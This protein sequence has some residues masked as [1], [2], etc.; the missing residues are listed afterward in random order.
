[1]NQFDVPV[2][3]CTFN[4]LECTKKVFERIR[5]VKPSKLYLLSDGPRENVKG[6]AEQVAAVREYLETH[7][8]WDCQVYKN[9]ADKNMGCGLRMSSGITWAFEHEEEL[10][11]IEDDCLPR[12]SFFQYC[13]ELLELY[14]DNEEIML[15]GGVNEVGILDE[16][17]SFI[18]TPYTG[19]WGWATWKR[20]WQLYDYGIT[21]WKDHN[22]PLSMRELMDDK[23]IRYYAKAFDCVYTHSLDTWDY[24]LQYLVF[25][26]GALTIV[27]SRSLITNI[28]FGLDATHTKI[29]PA[30][31]CNESYEMSFPM[32]VPSKIKNNEKFYERLLEMTVK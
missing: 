8:D 15:I 23:A 1:M 19:T 27:P 2:L 17:D 6:E 4:R 9:F 28:G 14:R 12:L 31:L 11:I 24:Q 18:F 13:R 10:I 3:F 7:I 29:E 30:E 25:Q 5:E 20:T 21:D 16:K 26:K 32:Q 22:I